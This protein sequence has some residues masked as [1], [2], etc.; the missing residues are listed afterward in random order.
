MFDFNANHRQDPPRCRKFSICF[1]S[2]LILRI[3][4]DQQRHFFSLESLHACDEAAPA[5]AFFAS[6]ACKQSVKGQKMC[7]NANA[8]ENN[9]PVN[10]AARRLGPATTNN[11]S[12]LLGFWFYIVCL[13]LKEDAGG[14]RRQNMG[15]S[16]SKSRVCISNTVWGRIERSAVRNLWQKSFWNYFKSELCIF[17]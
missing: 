7:K 17:K 2:Q 10:E 8:V 6:G 11:H 4:R 12:I 3:T 16:I 9:L 1:F 14:D 5:G 15:Q 13:L